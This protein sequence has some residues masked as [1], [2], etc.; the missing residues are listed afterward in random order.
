MELA[1]N[2]GET[3]SR[4]AGEFVRILDGVDPIEPYLIRDMLIQAG[5]HAVVRGFDRLTAMGDIPANSWPNVWVPPH[6]AEKARELVDRFIRPEKKVEAWL[7]T[8]CQEENPGEFGSCW[9]CGADSPF[10]K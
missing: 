10:I 1:L 5:V 7:C 4:L 2:D 6:Q 9:N 8:N 3:E